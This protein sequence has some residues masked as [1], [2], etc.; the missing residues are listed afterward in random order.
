MDNFFKILL[1]KEIPVYEVTKSAF[2]LARKKLGHKAF[3]ELN[4]DQIDYFYKNQPY[5]TWK[6]FRLLGVDGSTARLPFSAEIVA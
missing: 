5:K 6:G 3:I 4:K 1:N 2:S